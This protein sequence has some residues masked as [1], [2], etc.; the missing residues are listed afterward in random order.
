MKKFI[1]C[2]ILLMSVLNG[3]AFADSDNVK[4]ENGFGAQ[5]WL[6]S[7]DSIYESWDTI[8][9]PKLETTNICLRNQ[10][11]FAVFLF[12][13]PGIDSNSQAN[14]TADVTII[15]PDGEIYGEF[16]DMEVWQREYAFAENMIQLSVGNLGIMIDNEDQL[17][18]YTVK[19]IIKDKIKNINLELKTEFTAQEN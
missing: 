16:Q 11:I 6:I 5:L 17:G 1:C 13:N 3:L 7:D 8:E 15:S 2:A 10:P 14:V 19:A 12:V 18:V 4:S 9:V